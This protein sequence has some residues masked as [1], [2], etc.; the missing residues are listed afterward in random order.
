MWTR[1][2]L[3]FSSVGEMLQYTPLRQLS[4]RQKIK[5]TSSTRLDMN[6][7]HIP[8]VLKRVTIGQREDVHVIQETILVC[9]IL[10]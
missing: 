3:S 4:L 10:S 2:S 9:L 1:L 5:F 6:T 7:P 8:I